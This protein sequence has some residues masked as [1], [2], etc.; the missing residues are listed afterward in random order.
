MK[1]IIVIFCFAF[2]CCGQNKITNKV[3]FKLIFDKNKPIRGVTI[4]IKNS[5]PPVGTESDMNGNAVLDL[6]I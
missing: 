2:S 5:K 1:L 3:K 6:K 4:L